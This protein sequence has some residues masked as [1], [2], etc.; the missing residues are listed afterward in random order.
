MAG[1]ETRAGMRNHLGLRSLFEA[2]P[3]PAP[4]SGAK[5]SS[6]EAPG[7]PVFAVALHA[8]GTRP[9]FFFLNAPTERD[10]PRG[11]QIGQLLNPQQPF[12]SLSPLGLDGSPIPDTVEAIAQKYVQ[13]VRERQPHGPYRIGGYCLSGPV[14]LEMAR[15]LRT[16]GETTALL[17]VIEARIENVNR[18]AR[19]LKKLIAGV[20]RRI[21]LDERSRV[22]YFLAIR[23]LPGS[24]PPQNGAAE[25]IATK[26]ARHYRRVVSAYVPEPSNVRLVHLHTSEH[27]DPSWERVSSR[28]T[29]RVIPG[30]G[31][32]SA[33]ELVGALAMALG[34]CLDESRK[35]KPPRHLRLRERRP[36][37]LRQSAADAGLNG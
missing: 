29:D 19:M 16:L 17:V 14:V 25:S 9:P 12:Y 28:F 3:V 20:G 26:V 15:Q 21:G 22:D 5:T 37:G 18:R 36:K 7:G 30:E 1:T 31:D 33:A 35:R 27:V 24:V 8:A 34:R 32:T 13:Y 23:R 11:D 4:G 6:A 2:P 10:A